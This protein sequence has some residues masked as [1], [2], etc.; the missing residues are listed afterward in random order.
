[1]L[2]TEA[3]IRKL[4][5]LLERVHARGTRGGAPA[6]SVRGF[7]ARGVGAAPAAVPA[8]QP[9]VARPA[10]ANPT[11]TPRPAQVAPSMPVAPAVADDPFNTVPPPPDAA[12]QPP[13]PL[14]TAQP[15]AAHAAAVSRA[16]LPEPVV[17]HA[18]LSG[19]AD[20]AKFV[21]ALPAPKAAGDLLDDALLN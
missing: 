20:V 11:T 6:S 1:M 3:R 15:N 17:T 21:G 14:P 8:P 5:T 2:S 10:P 9:A 4:Q 12:T 19:G 7:S 18:H 16:S 13:T